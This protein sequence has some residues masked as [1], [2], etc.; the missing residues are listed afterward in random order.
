[1]NINSVLKKRLMIF[2]VSVVMLFVLILK[3]LSNSFF[4][5]I[6][7]YGK[8]QCNNFSV[9]L[10]NLVVEETVVPKIKDE[11]LVVDNDDFASIEF[12]TA[13]LNSISN[14]AIKRLQKYF[15]E[16]E[17]GN[18]NRELAVKLAMDDTLVQTKKGIFYEMPLFRVFDNVLIANL[19]V[20][21]PVRYQIIDK[22]NSQI[23]STITEY[24]INSALIE[25]HLVISSRSKVT[26]PILSDEE[27]VLVKV[28]LVMKVVNGD[29]PDSFFG[30]SIIGGNSR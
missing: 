21:I 7:E 22:I 18:L 29:I 23:V 26:V 27:D 28:P 30:S 8:Y 2:F 11:I 25:V 24:G 6:L 3:I 15:Y 12:N 9:G 4:S 13:I 5:V 1:M 16:I 10:I 17:N 19:G 20:N 14:N